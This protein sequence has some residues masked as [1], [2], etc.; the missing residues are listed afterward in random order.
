MLK[1]TFSSQTDILLPIRNAEQTIDNAIQS[2]IASRDEKF[3]IICLDDASVDKTS[4]KLNRWAEK[5]SRIHCLRNEVPVG[6]WDAIR[7]LLSLVESQYFLFMRAEDS[8]F[9]DLLALVKQAFKFHNADVVYHSSYFQS[10]IF[11]NCDKIAE[12]IAEKSQFF[13]DSSL[14][15]KV[16]RTSFFFKSV[17]NE[18]FTHEGLINDRTIFHAQKIVKIPECVYQEQTNRLGVYEFDHFI[19]LR[20]QTGGSS[21]EYTADHFSERFTDRIKKGLNWIRENNQDYQK[22]YL[23]GVLCE[24]IR[25]HRLFMPDFEVKG[26]VK[27]PN[28]F[29]QPVFSEIAGLLD[30]EIVQYYRTAVLPPQYR[31][32]IENILRLDPAESSQ[33]V[34]A[35]PVS[36]V[37]FQGKVKLTAKTHEI[38]FE[39]DFFTILSWNVGRGYLSIDKLGYGDPLVVPPMEPEG[40]NI[41]L[42]AH[43]PSSVRVRF[44]KPVVVS[45]IMNGTSTFLHET[46]CHFFISEQ[47]LGGLTGP[48]DQTKEIILKPGLYDLEIHSDATEGLHS[49]WRIRE[50]KESF[51]TLCNTP[52]FSDVGNS[53]AVPL[54]FDTSLKWADLLPRGVLI[55][56]GRLDL[57]TSLI[58]CLTKQTEVIDFFPD[59]QY[60]DSRHAQIRQAFDAF[61]QKHLHLTQT[62][63]TTEDFRKIAEKFKCINIF[64]KLG[65]D[66]CLLKWW[67]DALQAL[68]DDII[69]IGQSLTLIETSQEKTNGLCCSLLRKLS[70]LSVRDQESSRYVRHLG[71]A[72]PLRT[73][74]PLLF[75]KKETWLRV[76]SDVV[77]EEKPYLFV[78]LEHDN[79]EA[80]NHSLKLKNFLNRRI[81]LFPSVRVSETF[82][83]SCEKNVDR[84]VLGG[85]G[86]YLKW[87]ENAFFILTDNYYG[88]LFSILFSKSFFVIPRKD[89][90]K[91]MQ[92]ALV[93]LLVGFKM[94]DRLLREDETRSRFHDLEISFSDFEKNRHHL[95]S[96]SIQATKE[97]HNRI[98]IERVF[99]KAKYRAC[100]PNVDLKTSGHDPVSTVSPDLFLPKYPR[101]EFSVCLPVYN[102]ERFIDDTIRSV[103]RSTYGNFKVVISDNCSTDGTI[104]KLKEWA[105]TDSRIHLMLN[106]ENVGL[107]GN[108]RRIQPYM[109][110]RYRISLDADDMISPY[111][112][113]IVKLELER[114]NV[115]GVFFQVVFID[116]N[117]KIIQ[118]GTEFSKKSIYASSPAEKSLFF[119]RPASSDKMWNSYNLSATRNIDKKSSTPCTVTGHADLAIHMKYIVQSR[120]VIS[121]PNALYYRRIHSSS[122]TGRK[123]ATHQLDAIE[124]YRNIK[125]DIARWGDWPV[126]KNLFLRYKLNHLVWLYSHIAENLRTSL[127]AG[128]LSDMDQEERNFFRNEKFQFDQRLFVDKILML[129]GTG[130]DNHF[131][132]PVDFNPDIPQ[133]SHSTSDD[134]YY[135]N[136]FLKIFS[137]TVGR[138]RLGINELGFGSPLSLPKNIKLL[139]HTI[140]GAKCPSKVKILFK[141]PVG[142]S[143]FMN[144]TTPWSGNSNCSFL[145]SGRQIGCLYG[146][147]DPTPEVVLEPGLYE[148]EI[149]GLEPEWKHSCWAIR[150]CPPKNV[151]S[152]NCHKI[153]KLSNS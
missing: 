128:V 121:I 70:G 150:K 36:L 105:K 120:N 41:I 25:Y 130:N 114:R 116:E 95:V 88:T 61:H 110:T 115:D 107:I 82:L 8:F 24:L 100:I 147:N 75:S 90:P 125:N 27:F 18:S 67:G 50:S 39:N 55:N 17:S 9:P 7:Q 77:T 74:D 148:L 13:K 62:C 92:A 16:Y 33:R 98:A 151:P 64:G 69:T 143:G 126:Y 71:L 136:D 83:H 133:I 89:E 93:D 30:E 47:Y 1:L 111:Y 113:E 60:N 56:I 29:S 35:V 76:A 123:D 46:N 72:S 51:S 81:V 137:W 118:G 49:L 108:L 127:I 31:T 104:P 138:G 146:P 80:I 11:G 106:D 32:F 4:E 131:P 19:P 134:A 142:I 109:N 73:I 87:L 139:T 122:I 96:K 141:H 101:P 10:K 23:F 43:C 22:A 79:Y 14:W 103:L 5:D 52:I 135:E 145:V 124:V 42:S 34:L 78:C 53:F 86:E 132:S 6:F 129:R 144:G 2:V 54:E 152:K 15:N 149:R 112:M 26:R 84:V 63:H 48:L 140:L 37:P 28:G 40:Q 66:D 99:E 45:G 117:G 3:R 91:S 44:K 59:S 38:Y 102:M 119:C 57:G 94:E 21:L 97:L 12:T 85:P 58:A 153:A 68:P 20:E 65:D